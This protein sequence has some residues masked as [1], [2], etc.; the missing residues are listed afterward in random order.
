[1]IAARYTPLGATSI[2]RMRAA[3]TTTAAT[4]GSIRDSDQH[5]SGQVHERRHL[6][7][8]FRVSFSAAALS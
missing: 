4:V 5:R 7:Q 3:N 1:M 6:V 8:V 2:D